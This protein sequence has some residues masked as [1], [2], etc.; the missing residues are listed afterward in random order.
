MYRS[1]CTATGLHLD[2]LKV[3]DLSSHPLGI[4]GVALQRALRYGLV[5]ASL[6]DHLSR[7]RPGERFFRSAGHWAPR[8]FC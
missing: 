4:T 3:P 5:L 2:D 6:E 7:S 1:D 8:S